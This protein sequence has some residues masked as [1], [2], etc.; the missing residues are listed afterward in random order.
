MT[1]SPHSSETLTADHPWWRPIIM[2]QEPGRRRALALLS[3]GLVG[4]TGVADF[5]IG[6]ELSLHVFY[7]V[8][9]CLAFASVGARF[10]VLVAIA[11]AASEL[12]GDAAAGAHYS[13]PLVPWANAIF[14][15][16]TFLI[17]AWLLNSVL[18]LQLEME[19]RVHQRTTDLKEALAER[20]RL[21]KALLEIGER[22]R[23]SIGHDL[24]DGLGQHLTGTAL[25]GQ[26]L[27]EKLRG[28]HLEEEERDL[29]RVVG[30]IEEG[31]DKTRRIA[32]GLLL[33]EIQPDALAS[34]LQEL[35]GEV[36]LQSRI[37]CSFAAEG[38]FEV[39]NQ[40]VATHLFHIAKEAVHNAL[41][42][43]RARH[44]AIRLGADSGV[45][46]LE[47]RDDG[48][49]LPAPE[50]RPRGLGLRIM[51][52]RAEIIGWNFSI[53]SGQLDGTIVLCQSLRA[54]T[55]HA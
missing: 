24:H 5:L 53:R 10:G 2:P 6:F 35:A 4:L 9:V 54:D 15:S 52:H 38:A 18:K 11:A 16:S 45:M 46:T 23:R 26:V 20:D 12:V 28:R 31:I 30:L 1:A 49:G 13:Q 33:A 55:T 22:E 39:V 27:G 19:K 41:R 34:A 47:I 3:L 42:H 32:Q 29:Q 44:V 14:A 50:V 36:S 48:V 17:V 8:P 37:S 40:G 51:A 21:E 43:G 7:I 25:A